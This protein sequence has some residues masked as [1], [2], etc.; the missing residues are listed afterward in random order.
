L[1]FSTMDPDNRFNTKFH[2]TTDLGVTIS[3]FGDDI[4]HTPH[5]RSIVVDTANSETLLGSFGLGSPNEGCD[6]AGPGVGSSGLSSNCDGV[7]NVL[8]A[9]GLNQDQPISNPRGSAIVFDLQNPGTIVDLTLFN[10]LKDTIITLVQSI[11]IQTSLTVGPTGPNGVVNVTGFDTA[12]D[13]VKQVRIEF[14]GEGAVAGLGLCLEA[15][16]YKFTDAQNDPPVNPPTDPP[17]MSPQPST[18]PSG[19]P[20]MSSQLPSF[21]PTE[22]Q[23]DP[24]KLDF[25]T[26][27]PDNRFNT[28]FHYTTDLGV[29]ISAFGEDGH[30][31]HNRSIVVDTS[32]SEALMGSLGLG[33]PNEGCD[34]AGPGVGSSGLASNCDG[35]GNVLIAQ[36]SNQDQPISNPR[37]SE[38]VFDLQNPG[39]I[40][41]LTL[42]NVLKDAIITFVQSIG[43]ST[44]FTL[45]PTGP[46]GVVKVRGFDAAV[47]DVTQVRIQFGGEGAVAGLGLCL[48]AVTYNFTDPENDPPAN[49]PTDPP[50]MSPQPSTSP[51]GTP[52]MS[53]QPSASPSQEPLPVGDCPEDVELLQHIGSTLYPT[54]PIVITH[55][56]TTSVTFT[57]VN[58]FTEN[59][60]RIFTQYHEA[61]SGETD[62]FEEE[63]LDRG[64]NMTYT[65]YCMKHVP[66][67]I[68]DIWVSDAAFD[69]SADH[70]VVPDCCHAP[71]IDTNPKVQYTFKLHCVSTCPERRLLEVDSST[72]EDVIKKT[73][74]GSAS[75]FSAITQ[76]SALASAKDPSVKGHF[77]ASEDFPCGEKDNMVYACHYSARHGYQT[78]CVPE[79][80]SDILGFYPKDY[81]GPC[82][83]GYGEHSN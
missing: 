41:D 69:D 58:S 82:V 28:K 27:D 7:G 48:E 15:V 79:P 3:A 17:T 57:V 22:T 67:S 26:M 81:C 25:S 46:N 40:V 78:F 65:A 30:T 24:Y 62:C 29:T 20:T 75:E 35:V 18:S 2:Y 6:P 13:D 14:A 8:I 53:S 16:T 77:C 52:S 72:A 38:I 9:Q 61:E 45:G 51:S 63:N 64:D 23:C 10:V 54:I 44:S 66:I 59:V 39:T 32:N 71:N 49:P 83:G 31:P 73:E 21:S 55:Q 68:V 19:T 47:D 4:G 56:D 36:G 70:A 34:P 76:G 50:T 11:G 42:F 74:A 60:A 43:K 33:S 37:G 1:D 12:V 5:N 80:D